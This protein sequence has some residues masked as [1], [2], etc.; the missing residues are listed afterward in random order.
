MQTCIILRAV[1]FVVK[2]DIRYP[3][4]CLCANTRCDRQWLLHQVH[5]FDYVCCDSWLVLNSLSFSLQLGPFFSLQYLFRFSNVFFAF[6]QKVFNAVFLSLSPFRFFFAIMLLL[7]F[8]I[9]FF[10]LFVTSPSVVFFLN[11]PALGPFI[12]NSS[13][14]SLWYTVFYPCVSRW[15]ATDTI[16]WE[17]VWENSMHQLKALKHNIDTVIVY[18]WVSYWLHRISWCTQ[19]KLVF[20]DR[21]R[22]VCGVSI[23]IANCNSIH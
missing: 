10:S 1:P 14:M 16:Q 7:I 22:C 8:F 11:Q 15:F 18:S 6:F 4:S 19:A 23:A 2:C 12:L 3:S 5:W 17:I 9:H 21:S 13:A 20:V